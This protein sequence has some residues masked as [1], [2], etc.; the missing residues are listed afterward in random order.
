M[1]GKAF[2]LVAVWD[3]K[4][5]FELRLNKELK[6]DLRFVSRRRA[7]NQILEDE[8]SDENFVSET[9]KFSVFNSA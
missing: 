1:N 8:K 3:Q 2:E 5:L 7:T 6:L 9:R 4:C